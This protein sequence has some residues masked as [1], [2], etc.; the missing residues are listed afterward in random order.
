[1]EG[2]PALDDRVPGEGLAAVIAVP[3]ERQPAGGDPLRLLADQPVALAADRDA[4]ATEPGVHRAAEL[5]LAAARAQRLGLQV[6][7][8]Q[9]CPAAVGHAHDPGPVMAGIVDH[10]TRLDDQGEARAVAA[11]GVAAGQPLVGQ[12]ADAEPG[13]GDPDRV[14]LVLEDVR[15][16]V[17]EMLFLGIHLEPGAL[18]AVLDDQLM[19]IA[20]VVVPSG[21]L[22]NILGREGASVNLDST[23][24]AAAGD[25]WQ[26]RGTVRLCG[27]AVRPGL[28]STDEMA[29]ARP[30]IGPCSERK[31][32]RAR[33]SDGVR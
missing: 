11:P 7:Q 20:H 6:E 9:P 29:A 31:T 15:R 10:P 1:M 14:A 28:D 32:T 16:D 12:G 26:K 25:G 30:G 27:A 3:E 17:D 5:D 19:Q 4:H 24:E 23:D 2:E 22:H 13:I 33:G 21:E 18:P 8:D